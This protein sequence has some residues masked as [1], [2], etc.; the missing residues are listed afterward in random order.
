M[1]DLPAQSFADIAVALRRSTIYEA[2]GLAELR[3]KAMQWLSYDA[4]IR[5]IADAE[6]QAAMINAAH[7]FFKLACEREAEIRHLFAEQPKPNND[8]DWSLWR[9]AR[10]VVGLLRRA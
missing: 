3:I 5:T 6:Q 2:D 1:T 7:S 9:V 10:S 8:N 4:G